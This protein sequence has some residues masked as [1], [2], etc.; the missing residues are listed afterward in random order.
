MALRRRGGT[1]SKLP[2]YVVTTPNPSACPGILVRESYRDGRRVINHTL[3]NP[4]DWTPDW[5]A[6][7]QAA[8]RDDRLA[9][10]PRLACRS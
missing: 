10:S 1:D 9:S 4:S 3:A 8:L 7:L 6:A 5:I 2:M